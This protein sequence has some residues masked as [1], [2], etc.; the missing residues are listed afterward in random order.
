MALRL[1]VVHC[2]KEIRDVA[3]N[4]KDLFSSLEYQS[5]VSALCAA[6]FGCSNYSDIFRYFL[7]SPS[8]SS[9]GNFFNE[10]DLFQKLN[11]RHRRRLFSIF[12]D[13]LSNPSRYQ[14]AVD[15]T[16]TPHTGRKI[17]GAYVWRD[18]TKQ[19]NVFGHKI[20]VVGIID[21]RTNV[22]TPVIWEVLH[23]DLS[24][25]IDDN[26]AIIHE[27]GW[28]V[29][30]RLLRS[31]TESGFPKFD[32]SMDSWFASEEMFN[33]LD[34]LGFG[35][36]IE[37][38]S[39]RVV[40][41]HGQKKLSGHVSSFFKDKLRHTIYFGFKAK[42]ASE[43]ILVFKDSMRKLKVVAV[44]N[45]KNLDD[46]IFAY[47]VSNRLTWNASRIWSISRYR[48]AIEVQFRELKQSFALGEAAVRS[49]EAVETSISLSVI[50][51]TVVR[52]LQ[53]QGVDANENQNSRPKPAGVIVQRLE[54]ESISISLSKLTSKHDPTYLEAFR[55]RNS[56][57]NSRKKPAEDRRTQNID[58]AS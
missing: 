46:P 29:A 47:Y 58:K 9:I 16:I 56:E 30:V 2:P 7:F 43:A 49:K 41:S 19:C 32:V 34:A 27:K 45:S 35:F 13:I 31:I 48:W 18:H 10:P 26:D 42:F 40:K 4:F 6:I 24:D 12:P 38:K 15:D 28:E 55:R 14:Y 8:V 25:Q 5:F 20:L 33:Q 36:V 50:A 44:G 53:K 3:D 52:I 11:R 57:T 22:L 21:R 54:R 1:P 37:I 23:R 51:L 39:N 17:W